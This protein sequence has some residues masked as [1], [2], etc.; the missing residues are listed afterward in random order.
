MPANI[1]GGTSL[2]NTL[3][4]ANYLVYHIND[5]DI[6]HLKTLWH[7]DLNLCWTAHKS[8]GWS[9][10]ANGYVCSSVVPDGV[11]ALAGTRP[12]GDV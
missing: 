6:L 7:A 9:Q 1:A 8:L 11:A 2:N 3:A 10:D 4:W 5:A 12:V